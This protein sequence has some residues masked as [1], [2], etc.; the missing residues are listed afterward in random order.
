MKRSKHAFSDVESLIRASRQMVQALGGWEKMINRAGYTWRGLQRRTRP[1]LRK[2]RRSCAP[3]LSAALMNIGWIGDSPRKSRGSSSPDK[4]P[5]H[6]GG[7]AFAFAANVIALDD[8]DIHPCS[9]HAPFG[10]RIS[11]HHHGVAGAKGQHIA[12]HG[13][14]FIV[15]HLNKGDAARFQKLHQPCCHERQIDNGQI[16]IKRTEA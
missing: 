8:F 14:K 15:G 9:A 4:R 3:R 1:I 7:A 2:R 5:G 13:F 16:R 12:A 10:F 6:A 11:F